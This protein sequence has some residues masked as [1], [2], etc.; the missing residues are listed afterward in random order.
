MNFLN[1]DPIQALVWA[2]VVNGVAAVPL[3]TMIAR[4]GANKKIMGQYAISPVA[5]VGIWVAF[6]VMALAAVTMLISMFL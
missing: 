2:A 1:I 4:I 3:L 6:V 5:R